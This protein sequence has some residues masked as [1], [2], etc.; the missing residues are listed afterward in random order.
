MKEIKS[1]LVS[2]DAAKTHMSSILN[3]ALDLVRSDVGL[4][5]VSQTLSLRTVC[6]EV[7][8]LA[9]DSRLSSTVED[10]RDNA[11]TD[12]PTLFRGDGLRLKQVRG[13]SAERAHTSETPMSEVSAK[14]VPV[15]LRSLAPPPS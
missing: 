10:L 9:A 3:R 13:A 2:L 12:G 6:K 5:V 11:A 14:K 4:S 15:P 7:M 8:S 1:D